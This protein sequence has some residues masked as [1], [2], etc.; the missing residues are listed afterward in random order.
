MKK[1]IDIGDK[2]YVFK[3]TK[4]AKHISYNNSY[5]LYGNN[6]FFKYSKDREN[7]TSCIINEILVSKLCA[8]LKVPCVQY[9]YAINLH[10]IYEHRGVIS[11][12]FLSNGE[13]F[14]SLEKMNEQEVLSEYPADLYL[15]MMVIFARICPLTTIGKCNDLNVITESLIEKYENHSKLLLPFDR[16][17]IKQN[18]Q[19]LQEINQK[20]KTKKC[21]TIDECV[22][23]IELFASKN[24]LIL[25]DNIRLNLQK[26]AIVDA[27]TK[28]NDRHAGNLGLI[29][30]SKTKEARLAPMYDNGLSEYFGIDT[31]LLDYPQAVNCYLKLTEQDCEKINNPQTE[32]AKFYKSARD[33]YQEGGLDEMIEN[34]QEEFDVMNSFRTKYLDE[35][36]GKLVRREKDPHYWEAVKR[37]YQKGITYIDANLKQSQS[38]K[39]FVME[40]K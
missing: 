39:G 24:D 23:S 32:I 28:Q 5:W 37:N 8:N 33:F 11:I 35:K 2:P 1:K 38:Y 17:F 12:S 4:I 15:K 40:N 18:M 10:K 31:S 30:N 36:K 21:L 34:M 14:I 26:I 25:D 29:F 19:T 9:G 22:R 7:D 3:K 27:L 6:Y 13:K 16:A 20:T